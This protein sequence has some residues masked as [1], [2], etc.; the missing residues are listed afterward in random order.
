VNTIK[1]K[2]LRWLGQVTRANETFPCR[3][4]TF[5]K[6]EGRRSAVRPRI[7]W[8]DNVEQDRIP[9]IRGWKTKALY[10]NLWRRTTVE[11]KIHTGL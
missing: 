9:G 1:L 10:R 2:R 6:P 11:G 8:L 7:R 4:V 5:S 3:N